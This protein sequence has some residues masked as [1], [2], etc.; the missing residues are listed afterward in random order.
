MTEQIRDINS[1][2][3]LIPNGSLYGGQVKGYFESVTLET[4]TPSL[5]ELAVK[6]AIG[7]VNDGT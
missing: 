7:G 5:L 4:T 1:P 3:T 6:P 2:Q